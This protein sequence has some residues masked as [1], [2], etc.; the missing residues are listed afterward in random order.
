MFSATM[1]LFWLNADM[2]KAPKYWVIWRAK[3]YL[4]GLS[5]A[6]TFREFLILTA[7]IEII[8][9]PTQKCFRMFRL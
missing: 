5:I 9:L 2:E 1:V 3:V 7:L 4:A 6:F 8:I